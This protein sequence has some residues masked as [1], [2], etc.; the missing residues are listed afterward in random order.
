MSTVPLG[1]PVQLKVIA[2]VQELSAACRNC[3]APIS[4]VSARCRACDCAVPYSCA[5]CNRPLSWISLNLPPSATHPWGALTRDGRP[6]CHEHRITRCVDCGEL[7]ASREMTLCEVGRHVD[8]ETRVGMPP[9]V[10]PVFSYRCG[11]CLHP[12]GRGSAARGEA[13]WLLGAL[14]ASILALAAGFLKMARG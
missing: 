2:M 12:D 13:V 5:E 1:G 8:R 9:R 14:L 6:V 7:S 11:G 3:G 4:K 10:E